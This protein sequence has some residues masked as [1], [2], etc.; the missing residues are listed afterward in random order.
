VIECVLCGWAD[1]LNDPVL[2]VYPKGGKLPLK[3]IALEPSP[4]YLTD[5]VAETAPYIALIAHWAREHPDQLR[6]VIGDFETDPT[7]RWASP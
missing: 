1:G 7:M 2:F 3:W 5:N 4:V 6:S